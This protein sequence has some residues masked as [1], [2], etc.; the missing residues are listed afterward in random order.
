MWCCF[1][2]WI[3]LS[4]RTVY[5]HVYMLCVCVCCVL[6]HWLYHLVFSWMLQSCISIS[7]IFDRCLVFYECIRAIRRR[8]FCLFYSLS[9]ST[10]KVL[11]HSWW[12]WSDGRASERWLREYMYWYAVLIVC[13]AIV[14]AAAPAM[15]EL[16]E[17]C[18]HSY[19]C[20]SYSHAFSIVAF[21]KIQS[22]NFERFCF[23]LFLWR[24]YYSCITFSL[25]Q[26]VKTDFKISFFGIMRLK[27]MRISRGANM[28][29]NTRHNYLKNQ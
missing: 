15:G 12:W 13:L 4:T 10:A 17:W 5:G 1:F 26:C 19:F 23:F 29:Q 3:F 7:C 22:N 21:T 28:H 20:L 16:F 18:G 27:S 2:C 6:F 8:N 25:T 14:V 11:P 9:L 24:S